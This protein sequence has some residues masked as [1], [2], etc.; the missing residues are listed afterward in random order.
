MQATD[1]VHF[2]IVVYD[3]VEPIDIGATYGV[4]SMARRVL[5]GIAMTLVAAE[6]GPVVLAGGMRV[7]AE[8]GFADGGGY[9]AVIVCGG[10]GWPRQVEDPRM[11]AFLREAEG[12]M[13]SACTGGMILAAAGRLDGK[14]AT[15]R[16]LAVGAEAVAPLR[17]LGERHPQVRTAEARL[18]DEGAVVTGGGV[19]LAIDLTLHLVERFYGADAAAEVTRIIE[20]GAAR[21]ANE[22]A[23]AAS[24]A[25]E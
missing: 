11:L 4:L 1:R 21:R 7:I 9:D 10:P 14:R 6:P 17:L 3:G 12:V 8:R 2:A 25:A 24:A 19:T 22:A 5:P 16:R 18:V 13:A 20:Y 23:F 15:T